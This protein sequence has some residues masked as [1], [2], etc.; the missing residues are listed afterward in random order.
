MAWAFGRQT[1]QRA[2]PRAG[3]YGRKTAGLRACRPGQGGARSRQA[4][5]PKEKEAQPR[6]LGCR[7][8]F[9]FVICP[10]F[11]QILNSFFVQKKST[12]FFVQKIEK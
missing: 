12:K 5:G 11:G 6:A 8:Y 10:D 9:I 2:A 4:F 7:F 3:P 1:G